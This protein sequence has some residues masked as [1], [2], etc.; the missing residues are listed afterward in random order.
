M[1]SSQTVVLVL[2]CGGIE[3]S[4]STFVR[5]SGVIEKIDE[6]EGLFVIVP[7]SGDYPDGDYMMVGLR[8]RVFSYGDKV[9]YAEGA[10]DVVLIANQSEAK[11][12]IFTLREGRAS[13]VS[14]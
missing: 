6:E 2:V 4:E 1:A 13:G 9:N 5:T 12:V 14:E 8:N 10:E 3:L 7:P 11:M